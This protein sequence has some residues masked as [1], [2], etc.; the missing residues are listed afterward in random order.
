MDISSPLNVHCLF[1]LAHH[2]LWIRDRRGGHIRR[3]VGNYNGRH[4]LLGPGVAETLAAG[5]AG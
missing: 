1:D 5:W 3:T 2:I 4:V